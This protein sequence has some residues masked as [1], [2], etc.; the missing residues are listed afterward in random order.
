MDNSQDKADHSSQGNVSPMEEDL[1]CED[2]AQNVLPL[3]SQS[4]EVSSP[5]PGTG[6]VGTAGGNS[7]TDNTSRDRVDHFSQIKIT[8]MEAVS[9]REAE[10]GNIIASNWQD[11]E[12]RS[13]EIEI[14]EGETVAGSSEMESISTDKVDGTSQTNT[15]E[16]RSSEGVSRSTISVQDAESLEEAT[17]TSRAVESDDEPSEEIESG[18]EDTSSSN[19]EH[20]ANSASGQGYRFF[21]GMGYEVGYKRSIMFLSI[22]PMSLPQFFLHLLMKPSWIRDDRKLHQAREIGLISIGNSLRAILTE[23]MKTR[24]PSSPP[25][26]LNTNIFNLTS[27]SRP[28]AWL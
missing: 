21:D 22:Y 27:K 28:S 7:T 23:T 24:I 16:S 25:R 13:S 1:P 12:A 3:D 8:Q 20:R 10:P 26:I 6:E 9:L 18:N 19:V 15:Q 14:E 5:S 2:N 17:F 4:L 11:T